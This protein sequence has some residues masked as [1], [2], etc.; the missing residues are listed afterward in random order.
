[1]NAAHLHLVLNHIPLI[2][3]GFTLILLIIA[4]LRNSSELLTIALIFSVMVALITIP[5]Y[6][7]GEPAEEVVEDLPGVSESV[8]EQHEESAEISF[9]LAEV[10][11][12]IALISLITLGYSQNY[13]RKLSMITLILLIMS[14]GF[15]VWTAN[16]GGK[17]QHS[18]IRSGNP[19]TG[20]SG[21]ISEE[22]D[23]DD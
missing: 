3:I 4:F 14:G 17:I 10:T 1:M 20:S 2:G 7:T 6:L 15:M 23:H 19:V 16:L 9:I 11:G 13:G 21:A 18:E 8:I 5:V 22:R 12:A